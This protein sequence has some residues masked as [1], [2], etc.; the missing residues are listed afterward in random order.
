[1][2]A[3]LGNE[4]ELRRLLE[5]VTVNGART[6]GLEDY[7]TTVGSRADLVVLDTNDHGSVVTTQPEK[8]YVIKAGSVVAQNGTRP[9]PLLKEVSQ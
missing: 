6:L 7:G 5:M 8:T 9:A 2:A 4:D 3:H 1:V